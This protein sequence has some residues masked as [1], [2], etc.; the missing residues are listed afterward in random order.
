MAGSLGHGEG[1]AG[2]P[3]RPGGHGA[4]WESAR[5]PRHRAHAAMLAR[6]LQQL[7]P[8]SPNGPLPPPP[9]RAPGPAPEGTRGDR[10][11]VQ[12]QPPTTGRTLCSQ[13]NLSSEQCAPVARPA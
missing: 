13:F 11:A 2:V 12:G 1:G 6:E 3:A 9:A 10:C 4:G 8:R 5:S 7:P